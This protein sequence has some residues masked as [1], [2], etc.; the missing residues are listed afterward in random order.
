MHCRVLVV[1]RGSF[2]P[3]ILIK[4]LNLDVS[5]DNNKT[6]VYQDSKN[7]IIE[8]S[9]EACGKRR[10]RKT[11][12]PY[13]FIK[14][15]LASNSSSMYYTFPTEAIPVGTYCQRCNEIGPSLHSFKCKNP[16]V[17]SLY[18]TLEGIVNCVDDYKGFVDIS[19]IEN[20]DYDFKDP[21]SLLESIKELPEKVQDLISEDPFQ[22]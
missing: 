11:Y 14:K 2:D 16:T 15:S 13:G 8:K 19:E 6:I 22:D 5:V 21:D 18:M 20:P 12:T 1:C 3:K 9:Y 17:F 10:P 4:N 7:N